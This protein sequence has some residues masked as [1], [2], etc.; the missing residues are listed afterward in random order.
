MPRIRQ[1]PRRRSPPRMYFSH[2]LVFQEWLV[3]P[4]TVEAS[5]CSVAKLLKFQE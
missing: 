2:S 4:I 3:I 1:L 5:R